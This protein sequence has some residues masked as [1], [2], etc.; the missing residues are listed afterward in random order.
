M[1]GIRA[2]YGF[3]APEANGLHHPRSTT[4]GSG[5]TPGNLTVSKLDEET[6]CVFNRQLALP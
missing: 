1:F 3:A 6:D 4:F 2:P 5:M